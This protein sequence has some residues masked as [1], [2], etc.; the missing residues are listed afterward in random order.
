MRD[1]FANVVCAVD[2]SQA[3][4]LAASI[5]ARVA[6]PEGVLTLASL[7]NTKPVEELAVLSE[8][9]DFCRRQPRPEGRPRS[10]ERQRAGRARGGQ[11]RPGRARNMTPPEATSRCVLYGAL[12]RVEPCPGADCVFSD[13]AEDACVLRALEF[14]VAGRPLAQHL[15]DLRAAVESG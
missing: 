7:E 3:G 11:P 13:A 5:A 15:L 12:G 10:R 8:F 14:E 2:D 6:D 9:A 4:T 1:I